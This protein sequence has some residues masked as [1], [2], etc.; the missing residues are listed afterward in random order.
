M[1]DSACLSRGPARQEVHAIDLRMTRPRAHPS[2]YERSVAVSVLRR[3]L[4]A[5]AAIVLAEERMG[6]HEYQITVL[7]FWRTDEA[8]S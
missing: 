1:I 7:L 6:R 5:D 4:G 3:S 8:A 2:Q